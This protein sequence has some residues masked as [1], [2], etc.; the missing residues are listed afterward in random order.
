LANQFAYIN[1]RLEDS[2]VQMYLIYTK[3][4]A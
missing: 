4:I 2:V 1:S 3:L